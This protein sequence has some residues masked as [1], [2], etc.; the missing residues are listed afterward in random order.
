MSEAETAARD[1]Q[2]PF[3]I[4]ALDGLRGLA[5]LLVLL[6]HGWTVYPYEELDSIAP[7]NALFEAG[8]LGATV[9][10]VIS[11]FLVTSAMLRSREHEGP[12]QHWWSL[13]RR[14]ARALPQVLVLLGLILVLDVVDATDENSRET[15][16]TSATRI[17]TYTWNWYLLDDPLGARADLGHLWY[18]SVELH[19]L[20]GLAL[21]ITLLGAGSRRRLVGVLGFALLAVVWWRWHVWDTAGWYASALR[22]TTRADGVLYG[23]LAAAVAPQVPVGLR[24]QGPA[25]V[26]GAALILAGL[27]LGAGS[28]GLE[29]YYK[30][31]GVTAGIACALLVMGLTS[32]NSTGTHRALGWLPLQRLGSAWLTIYIWHYPL[33]WAL[34]RHSADWRNL[35][36]VAVGI[37]LVAAVTFL[38]HRYFD[39]PVVRRIARLGRRASGRVDRIGAAPRPDLPDPPRGAH[40]RRRRDSARRSE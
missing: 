23:A 37:A 13:L 38:M 34:S 30:G 40:R 32:T 15:T 10:L 6:D 3:R 35:S 12:V 26:G 31:A 29:Q 18:L 4:T 36:R 9:L 2:A 14:L 5:I 11:G 21:L 22:T 25:I 24:R 16:T 7:F 8:D 28:L 33:L 39:T 20:V 27:V 19:V 1:V 17:A